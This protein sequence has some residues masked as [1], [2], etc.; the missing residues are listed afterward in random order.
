[1][2][3]LSAFTVPSCKESRKESCLYAGFFFRCVFSVN[4]YYFYSPV[5][6][7]AFVKIRFR[8]LRTTLAHQTCGLGFF[9]TLR[10]RGRP[11]RRSRLALGASGAARRGWP[12]RR[13]CGALGW[14]RRQERRP[15]TFFPFFPSQ[16]VT[17]HLNLGTSLQRRRHRS[18][19]FVLKRSSFG[20]T[21]LPSVF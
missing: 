19:S 16:T 13:Q 18:K 7:L 15:D 14:P 17:V 11:R 12:G 4:G 2:L 8:L 3:V 21:S 6:C 20:A 1:M 10:P 9:R 5:S